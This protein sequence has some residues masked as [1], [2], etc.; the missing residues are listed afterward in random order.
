MNI[1]PIIF[2]PIS[3]DEVFCDLLEPPLEETT[4][5]GDTMKKALEFLRKH[6][7]KKI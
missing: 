4:E 6:P 7:P 1:A 2:F 3:D 5:E